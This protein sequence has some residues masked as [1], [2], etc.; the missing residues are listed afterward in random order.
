MSALPGIQGVHSFV[1]HRQPLA[2]SSCGHA[3]IPRLDVREASGA[4]KVHDG[5]GQAA[6]ADARERRTRA[7]RARP[8]AS[9][10]RT[11]PLA[12]ASLIETG[13]FRSCTR[14]KWNRPPLTDGVGREKVTRGTFGLLR[15][16]FKTSQKIVTW[17]VYG[18]SHLNVA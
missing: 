16:S 14:L 13:P 6:A 2:R 18:R 12:R 7:A 3:T 11:R 10:V 17:S 5:V 9:R 4:G 15:W 8:G 1:W